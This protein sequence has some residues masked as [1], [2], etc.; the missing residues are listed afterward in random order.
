MTRLD[1]HDEL[2]GT[3]LLGCQR[4]PRLVA[5]HL[6]VS[7]EFPDYHAAPV[8]SWGSAQA[9]LLIVGL[10]PGLH[11]ATRT[12]RGFVGDAS[13]DFLFRGLFRAG[14]ASSEQPEAA[15]LRAT[16]ITNVVKCLP[17]GNRPENAEIKACH[18]YL[19]REVAGF[20]PRAR[21]KHRIILC[22][23]GIAHNQVL[24]ALNIPRVKFTHGSCVPATKQL[25]VYSSYHPSQLNVNTGRLTKPMFDNLL[26]TIVRLLR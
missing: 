8:P 7:K 22:L 25:T 10:A 13:G 3:S 9:R 6:R 4:C 11:G 19:A 24:S 1:N 2:Y 5:N 17:P 14:L 21:M 16:R 23:G 18:M 20:M 12:G 15:K 26:N